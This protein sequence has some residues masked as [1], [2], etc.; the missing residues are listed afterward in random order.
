VEESD[1]I[2]EK[3]AVEE[4][5]RLQKQVFP[6]LSV[7]L[8]HGRLRP[9]EKEAAMRAF[10]KGETQILVATSVIEVGVDVPN[11]TLILIEGANRFGLAQLHQFRGRVG[12]GEH[13]SYCIL[14]ADSSSADAEERLKALEQTNDGFVLAEKDLEIRGPGEFFGRR[15][16]GLP[17]LQLASLLDMEMVETARAEAQKLFAADPA[18]EQSEHQLLREQVGR[19]WEHAGDVS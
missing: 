10:Y 5:E 16:S 11:A 14:V 18:L 6:E 4:Y 13:Q 1:K 2:D 17:E 15:Q 9:D 12:R 3:A 8:V 7:G 19:F